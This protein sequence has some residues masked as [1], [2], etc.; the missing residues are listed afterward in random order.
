MRV[1]K[2]MHF[3]KQACFVSLEITFAVHL[4]YME[5]LALIYVNYTVGFY[6]WLHIF[7]HYILQSCSIY[8][9][10]KNSFEGYAII[11]LFKSKY[12]FSKLQALDGHKKTNIIRIITRLLYQSYHFP[13]RRSGKNSHN[14]TPTRKR[15]CPWVFL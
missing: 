12:L 5:K 2:E 8:L 9:E 6:V 3:F 7:F 1:F 4:Q 14:Q 11:L 13:F 10:S 15:R